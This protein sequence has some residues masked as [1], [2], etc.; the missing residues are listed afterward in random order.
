MNIRRTFT[1]IQLHGWLLPL[2]GLQLSHATF[3]FI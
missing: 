1:Q 2:Q 3:H